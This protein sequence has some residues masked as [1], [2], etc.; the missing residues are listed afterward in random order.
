MNKPNPIIVYLE[1]EGM[2]SLM[3]ATK[4]REL[5]FVLES[6]KG[7]GPKV[8]T[9]YLLDEASGQGFCHL[10]WEWLK[11]GDTIAIE[12]LKIDPIHRTFRGLLVSDLEEDCRDVI[13][14]T[15]KEIG[16]PFTLDGPYFKVWG[17]VKSDALPTFL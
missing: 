2:L 15:L 6:F 14:K 10:D 5:A 17:H 13:F 4:W 11:S 1:T 16:V 8:C 3:N 12:W 7:Y 9:K